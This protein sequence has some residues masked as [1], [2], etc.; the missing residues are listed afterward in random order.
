MLF[1]E[2]SGHQQ[3]TMGQDIW[4]IWSGNFSQTNPAIMA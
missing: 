2:M 3:L 4:K 1:P